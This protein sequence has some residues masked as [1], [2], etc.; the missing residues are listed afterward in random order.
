MRKKKT[1]SSRYEADTIDEILS[2]A[3]TGAKLTIEEYRAALAAG[4]IR[5][6]DFYRIYDDQAKSHLV[7]IYDGPNL[8]FNPSDFTNAVVLGDQLTQEEYNARLA[9]GTIVYGR[10]YRI[11]GDMRKQRLL[12]IYDGTTLIAR[13]DTSK[14]RGFPLVFPF[15]FGS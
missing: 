8:F 13:R 12:A 7:A 5:A 2:R 15:I 6:G 3:V 4:T 14:R 10:L 11:Y 9:A 1:Y